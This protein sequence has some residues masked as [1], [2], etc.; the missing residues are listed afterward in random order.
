MVSWQRLCAAV[1]NCELIPL[2]VLRRRMRSRSGDSPA[3]CVFLGLIFL[4]LSK[5]L[6]RMPHLLE[7]RFYQ[8]KAEFF[9]EWEPT[10]AHNSWVRLQFYRFC[11]PNLVLNRSLDGAV[12]ASMACEEITPRIQLTTQV[13]VLCDGRV[14]ESGHPHT[15]LQ[16]PTRAENP[17]TLHWQEGGGG[18]EGTGRDE[19]G[20]QAAATFSAMVNETGPA[21]SQMLRRLAKEAWE[22]LQGA[23]TRE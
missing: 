13:V 19:G 11:G 6:L 1:I 9:S 7:T 22:A 5:T 15:L 23:A 3:T 12:W 16:N 4:D 14:L 18:G 21:S 20:N 8:S 17:N 10:L 2:L